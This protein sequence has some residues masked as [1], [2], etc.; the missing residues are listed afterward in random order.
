MSLLWSAEVFVIVDDDDDDD[1][2]KNWIM[3]A[4]KFNF[5]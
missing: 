1:N 4:L 2:G 3:Y 5:K